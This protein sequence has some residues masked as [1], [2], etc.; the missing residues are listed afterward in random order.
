MT[1]SPNTRAIV[2]IFVSVCA[3]S[4]LVVKPDSAFGNIEITATEE[5]RTIDIFHRLAPATVLLSVAYD[6]VH[7]L[8]SPLKASVGAAFIVDET[9]K[10]LTNAHLVD[11][12]AAV[13]ATLYDGQKVT[14]EVL[15]LDPVSDVAVLQLHST[16]KVFASVKLGDSSDLHVGQRALVVGSPFGLGFTLTTGI[17]SSIGPATGTTVGAGLQRMI[18]TTAPVNPG[19]SGGPLVDSQGRV[20][21]ITTATL[22]GA[23]NIGFAIPINVA[24]A[25]LEELKSTGR[26]ERA[27]LGV[28][29]KFVTDELMRLFAV[30]LVKG[31]LVV[32]VEDGSPALKSGLRPG[33]LYVAIEGDPWVLGGDILVSIEGRP[34]TTA[35]ASMEAIKGLPVGQKIR[36]EAVRNGERMAVFLVVGQRPLGSIKAKEGTGPQPPGAVLPSLIATPHPVFMSY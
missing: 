30:P 20:I 33:N 21:G 11:G 25:V 23:Q 2:F 28:T 1:L 12:A 7:P 29:V 32:D 35:E 8:T 36:I 3:A 9:G 17:I 22:I 27:W 24:K 4:S 26:I 5:R 34:L 14:V 15:G 18:Q 19:N 16:G 6:S 10:A 13:T 31:L